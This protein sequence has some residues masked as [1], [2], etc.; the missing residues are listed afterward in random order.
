MGGVALAIDS[1]TDDTIFATIPTNAQNRPQVETGQ[2]LVARD[3]GNATVTGVTVQ[4]GLRTGADVIAVAG[5]APN[6]SLVGSIQNAIDGAGRND[7]ILIPPGTYNEMVIMWKP[8]QLQGWGE[9]STFIDAIKTPAEKLQ[10]WRDNVEALVTGDQVSLLPGQ[11]EA[12][13]GIEPGTLFNE[14]GAGI[15]VLPKRRG[16]NRFSLGRNRNA[17]IDGFTISGADTGGGIILNGYAN[18]LEVSNNRV[19]NNTGFF[20]GGIRSGHPTLLQELPNGVRYTDANNNNLKIHNNQVVENGGLTGAGGGITIGK[21]SDNYQVTGNFVCGNFTGGHGAGI[22]HYGLSDNG[23]IADNTVLFNENFNQGLTVN[24]GGIL[25]SGQPP[26]GCPAGDIGCLNDPSRSLTEGS[27]DVSILRN[28]I[29]GNAAGA[30][31]GG[32]IRT[33][34]VNGQDLRRGRRPAPERLWHHIDISNNI[35][36]NNVAALSGAGISLQDTLRATIVNNTITNNDNA[37]VASEAFTPGNPSQSNPQSGAG[38]VSRAHSFELQNFL[39]GGEDAFSNPELS[40]NII[41]QNRMFYWMVE[42]DGSRSGL[43]PD[44]GASGLSCTGGNAPVYDDLAVLGTVGSLVCINCLQTGGADPLF[45]AEYINGN[46]DSTIFNPE[47]TTAIQA[48]P[49]MDEGGNFIRLRFGPLTQTLSTGAG[50]GTVLRGDYHI[51]IG[52]PAIDLSGSAVEDDI[53]GDVRPIGIANDIG[54]DEYVG[55]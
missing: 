3:N 47:V 1:W 2:L 15:L 12:F 22:A 19:V 8:V 13:G 54:A 43:C 27:G 42:D 4:I 37:S 36:A 7:L 32:G 23:L 51:Q 6:T 17:R 39:P 41:W 28:L 26:Q 48:P 29:K 52:S 21:G 45:V 25:V 35:L 31:D 46:R 16:A 11:E 24:G 50:T 44:L 5:P 53:D 40:D 55:P 14:E 18:Y 20:G 33:S 10:V 49:A 30:G 9:G 38:V 34:R